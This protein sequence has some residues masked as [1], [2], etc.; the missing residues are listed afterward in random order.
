[1]KKLMSL[2]LII[3]L[4]GCS[5]KKENFQKNK[6]LKEIINSPN[7]VNIKKWEKHILSGQEVLLPLDNS[8]NNEKLDSYE[9]TGIAYTKTHSENENLYSRVSCL[10]EPNENQYSIEEIGKEIIRSI[11]AGENQRKLIGW[12]KISISNEDAY[13]IYYQNTEA[14]N[15][16]S[17][18]LIKL[19]NKEN[20]IYLLGLV[21]GYENPIEKL[22]T[23]K[24]IL[25][26]AK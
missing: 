24:A 11:K 4:A 9:S 1:M 6:D 18:D 7:S 10:V 3:I 25:V 8:W 21:V 2:S 15:I 16:Y 22:K 5:D 14:P 17:L 23:I 26:N 13:L 12:N 19:K 20:I